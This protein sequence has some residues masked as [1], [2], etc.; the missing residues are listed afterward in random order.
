MDAQTEQRAVNSIWDKVADLQRKEDEAEAARLGTSYEKVR[1]MRLLQKR[2]WAL[3][4]THV[5]VGPPYQSFEEVL[6]FEDVAQ[7]CERV[8]ARCREYHATRG[9]PAT[10]RPPRPAD[11]K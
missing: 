1:A 9:G 5:L 10:I 11:P 6:S 2:I 4:E 7:V 8:A 3:P